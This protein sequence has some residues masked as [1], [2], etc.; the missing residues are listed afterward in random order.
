MDWAFASGFGASWAGTPCDWKLC[1]CL[2]IS[3]SCWE[4]S[5]FKTA[6]MLAGGAD[7]GAG[8]GV[9]EWSAARDMLAGGVGWFWWLLLA[10]GG[11]GCASAGG[12]GGERVSRCLGERVVASGG[13]AN[14]IRRRDG[15]GGSL[16]EGS[17]HRDRGGSVFRYQMLQCTTR[18]RDGRNETML[19]LHASRR[20]A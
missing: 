1:S 3:R 9:G 12:D 16:G 15:N 14:Q 4:G 6:G 19:D 17:V 5:R 2:A 7:E 13:R 10:H 18:S 20:A 8:V 11:G